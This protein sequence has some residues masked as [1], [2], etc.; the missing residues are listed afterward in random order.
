M[1]RADDGIFGEYSARFDDTQCLEISRAKSPD[2]GCW[3][4]IPDD[5]F[6]H[7]EYFGAVAWPEDVTL[8]PPEVLREERLAFMKNYKK[9][10]T[11]L[12]TR[13]NIETM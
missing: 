4:P 3:R 9:C 5:P 12:E 8:L 2:F 11:L 13:Y 7:G 6:R 1:C 10:L